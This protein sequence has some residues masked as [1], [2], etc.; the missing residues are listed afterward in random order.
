MTM[1]LARRSKT[2]LLCS[3]AALVLLAGCGG[4]TNQPMLTSADLTA[5]WASP[6]GA[7]LTFFP[8][9]QFAATG[10]N[11]AAY[12]GASCRNVT[13]SGSWQFLSPQGHSGPSPTSYA[14]GNVVSVAF[15]GPVS[16]L[17]DTEFSS[18]EINK[19][20]GL[21]LDLDP[22]TPCTG[23]LYSKKG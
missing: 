4:A 13:G 18:W 5:T 3:L 17:C 6:S 14:K 2:V 16:P 8:N 9:H 19:P 10:L 20:T 11:L 22:D 15:D 23:D 12:F 21:C 7:T 1:T